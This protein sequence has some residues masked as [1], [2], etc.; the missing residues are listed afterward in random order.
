M[1]FLHRS[2]RPYGQHFLT[3][4]Y[5]QCHDNLAIISIYLDTP[6][7]AIE[8]DIPQP[9]SPDQGQDGALS[10]LAPEFESFYS[11]IPAFI[12]HFSNLLSTAIQDL[13]M[14]ATI[15]PDGGDE[16]T[17]DSAGASS[18]ERGIS[19]SSRTAQNHNSRARAR[20]RRVR[21][22]MAPVPPL[23]SQLQD[24]VRTIRR[25]QLSELPAARRQM[26]ATAAAVVM[27]QGQILERTV[28]ILER[29]R[30]G[31]LARAT[32]AKAEHLATVAQGIE[33]KLE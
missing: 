22:S 23:S 2:F 30:H 15:N 28:V 32:K 11:H 25:V 4:F 31:A 5:S 20:D 14:L 29:V 8:L 7:A 26:A 18:S 12:L 3:R 10:L 24:R 21:S 9:D 1:F 13:R 27:T 16:D 19:G 6:C 33:G 17:G